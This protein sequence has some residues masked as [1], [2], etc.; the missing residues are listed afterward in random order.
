MASPPAFAQ[1]ELWKYFVAV[2]LWPRR[3]RLD[4]LGWMQNFTS[5]ELPLA[6]RLLEGFTYFSSELVAHMFRSAFL[7]VSQIVVKSRTNYFSAT[8]EWSRFVKSLLIVRV[9]GEQPSDADSGFIFARLARDKLGIPESQ[10]VPP[11]EALERLIALPT[12]N[13]MFVDD[14]VGSGEQFVSTW[15][16]IHA[17]GA[18]RA[19]FKSVAAAAGGSVAF[20]YVPVLCTEQGRDHIS[21][22]SPEVTIVPAHFVGN[23]H[24]A[25]SPDSVIWRNDMSATGPRFV[26]SASVRAGI[27][28]LDGAEGCW[29]GYRKLG[30]AIAFEHSWPDATLPIFYWNQNNWHPLLQK[31]AP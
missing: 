15:E 14:F 7:N 20:F 10:I 12:G 13:V 29:R 24:S 2:Q 18:A 16:R 26:E 23:Q 25:I 21:R 4:P 28:D 5:D 11:Q 31:A 17:L 8:T 9:T 30:L 19:S 27:P 1:S 3:A 6:L 22:H